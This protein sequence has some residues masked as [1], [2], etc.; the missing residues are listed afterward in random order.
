[1]RADGA[2]AVRRAR[3]LRPAIAVVAL[4][5]AGAGRGARAATVRRGQAAR[6]HAA[7]RAA[8]AEALLARRARAHRRARRV[9]DAALDARWKHSTHSLGSSDHITISHRE[10]RGC[11]TVRC[12]RG[13]HDAPRVLVV[14]SSYAGVLDRRHAICNLCERRGSVVSQSKGLRNRAGGESVHRPGQC[15]SGQQAWRRCS[16]WQRRGGGSGSAAQARREH[17]SAPCAQ[18]QRRQAA[19]VA[20]SA[21]STNHRP[22]YRHPITRVPAEH[23]Y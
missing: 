13:R 2:V 18:R 7:P 10:P 22:S 15:N 1:M 17:D 3:R 11:R 4:R 12:G 8:E 16:T 5:A 20:T 9:H 6:P 23:R 19:R 21:P 14:E